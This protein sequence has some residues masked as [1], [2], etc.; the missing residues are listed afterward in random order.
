M[1]GPELKAI[2][3]RLGLSVV[4]MG[5]AI[6]Y[7]GADKSVAVMIHRL[8]APNGRPIPPY[9]VRLAIMFDLWGVPPEYLG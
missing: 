8:E 5:R 9:V 1:T 4:Q 6:G 2:R 3:N 7:E